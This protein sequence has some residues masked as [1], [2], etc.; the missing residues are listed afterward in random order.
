MIFLH[1]GRGQK[2]GVVNILEQPDEGIRL[3]ET[4]LSC[5]KYLMHNGD[6]GCEIKA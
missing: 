3:L 5:M 1:L 4:W 6:F 2:N